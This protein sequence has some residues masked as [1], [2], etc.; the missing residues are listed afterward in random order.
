MSRNV[1]KKEEEAI[2]GRKRLREGLFL[3]LAVD[4]Y[5][6]VVFACIG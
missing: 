1:R 2:D 4:T 6:L 5:I 3:G